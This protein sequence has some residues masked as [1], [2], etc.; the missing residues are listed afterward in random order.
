LK[1]FRF[2]LADDC[3]L[4]VNQFKISILLLFHVE[5]ILSIFY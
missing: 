2:C 3:H 4:E 1:T 5:G